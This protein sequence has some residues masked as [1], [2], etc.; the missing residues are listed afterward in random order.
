MPGTPPSWLP[1]EVSWH[2][3]TGQQQRDEY[4]N[5]AAGELLAE[6]PEDAGGGFRGQGHVCSVT[7]KLSQQRLGE[8]LP[9]NALTN[10][11]ESR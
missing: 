10:P 4:T 9:S 2:Q 11:Q 5:T 1:D 3:E 8:V 6:V 7:V